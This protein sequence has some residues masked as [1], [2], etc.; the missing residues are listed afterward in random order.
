MEAWLDK[1]GRSLKSKVSSV[2]PAKYKL[3][4]DVTPH[5]DE[6]DTGYYHSTIGILRWAVELGR[7]DITCEVSQLAAFSAAP[8]QGHLEAVLHVF[9]Y[10]KRHDRSRMVCDAAYF[11][12]SPLD[13]PDWTDFYPGAK[14]AAEKLIPPDM[15]KPRGK[16]VCVTTYE[17]SDHAGDQVT[18]RSRTGVLIFCNRTPVV[19]YS[20]K[21]TS[22][23]TSSFGSEFSALKTAV[24]LTEGIIYKLRMMGVPVELPAIVL[25]D[26]QSVISN[27]SVPSS[28]LQKKSNSIAYHYVR[29]RAA[30]GLVGMV[31]VHTT[32]NLAD[33]L[34]KS[35][36][37]SVRKPLV[38]RILH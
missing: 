13:E 12:W 35:Q 31:Y 15:P 9:T 21:Q 10:L 30:M 16:V 24:E 27:S 19:W 37:G 3:E 25:G 8:M 22:I 34:T 17:D 26:N 38:G 28:M 11:D 14:E 32:D 5:L 1:R 29:E 7:M 23:E 18:R 2:F 6:E 36:P 20:K 4:L 33:M